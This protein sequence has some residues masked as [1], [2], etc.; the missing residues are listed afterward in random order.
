M[1]LYLRSPKLHPLNIY[2]GVEV[3][4]L[5]FLT[6]ASRD[7]DVQTAYLSRESTFPICIAK[8]IVP[9]ETDKHFETDRRV[10]AA[11][12]LEH[13]KNVLVRTDILIRMDL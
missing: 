8:R 11:F 2:E 1:Y 6:S 13:A 4:I 9:R 5:A 3:L 12:A 7:G 10:F